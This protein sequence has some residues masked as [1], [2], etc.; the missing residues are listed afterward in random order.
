MPKTTKQQAPPET[1]TSLDLT[2]IELALVCN[3]LSR[4]TPE[5]RL[6]YVKA[7][8]ESQR[9]NV[10]SRP[11]E[12]ISLNGKLTLYPTKDCAA[13]LRSRDEIELTV[14]DR[15]IIEG[16]YVVTVLAKNGKG[17][18]DEAIGA[19]ALEYPD[20]YIDK[21]GNARPHPLAGKAMKG[22]ERAD[23]FM[24]AETKA[25]RRATLSIAGLGMPEPDEDAIVIID[26]Q[27]T[28]ADREPTAKPCAGPLP[29]GEIADMQGYLGELERH[30]SEAETRGDNEEG[31]RLALLVHQMREKI[32]AQQAS[33][34]AQKPA[35]ASKAPEQ[36]KTAPKA[37]P[38][39]TAHPPGITPPLPV[40]QKVNE[41][42]WPEVVCHLGTAQ[43][44]LG[45]KLH[46]L[47]GEGA[48]IS[49]S[50]RWIGY[51]KGKLD[52]VKI[53]TADDK[54][55][56][57]GVLFAE[58]ALEDR[59]RAESASQSPELLPPDEELPPTKTV[60]TP[61][62]PDLGGEDE[63]AAPKFDWR[64]VIVPYEKKE[65]LGKKLGDLSAGY[66]RAIKN[67]VLTK[68]D[69]PNASAE[70]KRCAAALELA[71]EETGAMKDKTTTLAMLK[72]KVTDLVV[73]EDWFI[74]TCKETNTLAS[75]NS[76]V[77]AKLSDLPEFEVQHC[78]FHWPTIESVCR[79]RMAIQE[80][81]RTRGRKGK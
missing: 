63:P 53:K 43:G 25:K 33:A 56:L 13:Q 12:Y 68:I 11:F 67:Q 62:D 61:E 38:K 17:R 10:L 73:S 28:I 64:E 22:K 44:C 74:T 5:Q 37:E 66:L 50:E 7:I 30:W 3:D 18:T 32:A 4:L 6:S 15:G 72:D 52:A 51:L 29:D 57:R 76:P 59:R 42:N 79:E 70:Y 26:G 78:L 77:G 9:L 46:D 35:S 14:K 45:Q 49:T 80:G 47:V 31:A 54:N 71:L 81:E 75:G 60:E 65:I 21:Q 69:L 24:K 27:A 39:N 20:E 16:V 58:T 2:P 55:L 40:E 34:G 23:A 19:V 36:G 41:T 8:C 48:S 1:N